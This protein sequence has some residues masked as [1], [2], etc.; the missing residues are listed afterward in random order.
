MSI[1]SKTIWFMTLTTLLVCSCSQQGNLQYEVQSKINSD[2]YSIHSMGVEDYFLSVGTN[3]FGP[4]LGVG[5]SRVACLNSNWL[6][7]FTERQDTQV[8]FNAFDLSRQTLISIGI[9]G[10]SALGRGLGATD[11]A[12]RQDSVVGMSNSI[13]QI[14]SR[15][16]RE[17]EFYAFD[18]TTRN[19]T[20][21]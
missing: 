3:K 17:S 4:L 6:I 14:A 15:R 5:Y 16:G 7:F 9:E 1:E 10:T 11:S 18:L 19:Y 21:K 8:F 12:F 2:G 13:V 20:K